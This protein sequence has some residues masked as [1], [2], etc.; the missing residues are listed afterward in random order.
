MLVL[1]LELK[2]HSQKIVIR[3]LVLG[4]K[5]QKTMLMKR[6]DHLQMK[7]LQKTTTMMILLKQKMRTIRKILLMIPLTLM[8][9][10]LTLM[11]SLQ[12]KDM[13]LLFVQVFSLLL[14]GFL[15]QNTV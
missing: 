1:L 12:V 9:I 8:M 4:T 14:S 6:M 5:K 7:N 15:Q 13:V 10:P 11:I 2:Q 3:N